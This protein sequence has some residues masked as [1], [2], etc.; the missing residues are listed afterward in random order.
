[1]EAQ[2]TPAPNPEPRLDAFVAFQR[3]IEGC[4]LTYLREH[5][6]VLAD[7]PAA[8]ERSFPD[9]PKI[10][11][12]P[13]SLCEDYF[14]ADGYA[15]LAEALEALRDPEIR[16]ELLQSLDDFPQLASLAR[17]LGL[18]AGDVA[19]LTAL[20]VLAVAIGVV[21]QAATC[22][23]KCPYCHGVWCLSTGSCTL[24]SGHRGKHKC[25]LNHQWA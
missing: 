6:Q 11:L 20:V 3:A 10:I 16:T 8:Y 14:D 4:G 7:Q 1:M 23:T 5:F 21:Q 18:Q 15:H 13:G 19:P 9:F 22:G 12:V 2:D 17:R 25:S 24:G